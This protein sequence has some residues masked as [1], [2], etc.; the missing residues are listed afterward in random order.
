MLTVPGIRKLKPH[1]K[2]R[3]VRDGGSKGLRLMIEAAAR[4]GRK[5]WVFRYRRPGNG[6]AAKLTLGSCNLEPETSDK[7]PVIGDH[8]TLV[9]ARR[10][11]AEQVHQLALGNDPGALHKAAKHHRRIVAQ[12]DDYP[13]FARRYVVRHAKPTTRRWRFTARTLGLDP[14]DDALPVIPGSIAD[15]W[16]ARPAAAISKTEVVAEIDRAV[17]N[18]RGPTA[19]NHLLAALRGMFRW[20]VKRDA[21]GANPCAM[22]DPPVKPKDLRRSRKL[23][24]DELRWLW[25]ALA[26][27]PPTYAALVRFLLLTAVREKEAREAVVTEVSADGATWIVPGTRTKNHEDHLVGL[28]QLARRQLAAVP[29]VEGQAGYIFTLDGVRPI[30]GMSKWKRQLEERMLALA[31]EE[32]GDDAMIKQ[33]QLH[34]FRRNARSFLSRVTSADIAE[35]CLGHI[36]RGVRGHYDCHDYAQEKRDALAL[37]AREV[38]RIVSGAPGTVV[39]LRRKGARP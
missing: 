14:D 22:I 2:R 35:R 11:G 23:D 34:D 6:K 32:R 5:S 36:I 33:W 12:P 37:W 27:A 39:P 1:A 31:R 26:V 9:A 3:E 13:A 20:H 15:R 28:S 7:V 17:D 38:E 30:G 19:G 16:R 25:R 29:S 21:L 18:G 24:D 10:L 8:L 4:G